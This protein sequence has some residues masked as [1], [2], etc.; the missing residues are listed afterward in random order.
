MRNVIFSAAI[1]DWGLIILVQ[2]LSTMSIYS[3][4]FL[5]ISVYRSGYKRYN[6][7]F[8]E[9]RLCPFSVSLLS[10]SFYISFSFIFLIESNSFPIYGCCH[11]C[12][13]LLCSNF[14]HN[15]ATWPDIVL[16]WMVINP[17]QILL[18]LINIDVYTVH[19]ISCLCCKYGWNCQ[20]GINNKE[21][22]RFGGGVAGFI[23]LSQ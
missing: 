11:H 14:F 1:S 13:F 21:S 7:T 3:K 12:F 17:V 10:L 23:V 19:T 16:N 6:C 5:K 20:H 15:I 2:I 4:H 22:G 8:R 18:F 9:K